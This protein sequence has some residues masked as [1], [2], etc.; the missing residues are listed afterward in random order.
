MAL[1]VLERQALDFGIIAGASFLSCVV[2]RRPLRVF[3]LLGLGYLGNLTGS[4]IRLGLHVGAVPGLGVG[5]AL[6]WVFVG[7]LIMIG[8]ESGLRRLSSYVVPP[9]DSKPEPGVELVEGEEVVK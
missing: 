2:T 1:D 3:D 6:A 4:A 9:A 5:N 8:L 7:C